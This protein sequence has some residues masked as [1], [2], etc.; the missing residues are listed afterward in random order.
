MLKA[1]LTVPVVVGWR[2][3]H[4]HAADEPPKKSQVIGRW[5]MKG[6][7]SRSHIRTVTPLPHTHM[8]GYVSVASFEKAIGEAPA[9][10]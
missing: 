9:T 5:K 1:R 7:L 8:W 10:T 3:G 4:C 6:D 2:Q